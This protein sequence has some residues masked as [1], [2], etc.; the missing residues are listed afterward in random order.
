[1]TNEDVRNKIVEILDN[2]SGCVGCEGCKYV[3]IRKDNFLNLPCRQ[4]KI[5]DALIAAGIGDD[6]ELE[7]KCEVLQR[8]VDNLT[9]TLEEAREEFEEAE[10]R[11]KVFEEALD[12][13]ET[14]YLLALHNHAYEGISL[15]AM[16]S[17]LGIHRFFIEQAEKELAEE[18]K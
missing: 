15:Q 4:F 14:A 10:H 16:A 18:I 3:E 2:L 11:A 8:D 13:C 5:A 6:S 1:M 9:R 17:D 12:L 7:V